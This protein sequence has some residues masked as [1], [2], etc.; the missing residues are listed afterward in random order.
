MHLQ[1]IVKVF[2]P[3]NFTTQRKLFIKSLHADAA[4]ATEPMDKKLP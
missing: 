3:V 2:A 1:S 4:T